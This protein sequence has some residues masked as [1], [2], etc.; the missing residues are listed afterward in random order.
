MHLYMQM[1]HV[2]YILLFHDLAAMGTVVGSIPPRYDPTESKYGN[3]RAIRI[4]DLPDVETILITPNEGKSYTWWPVAIMSVHDEYKKGRPWLQDWKFC[5]CI[6]QAMWEQPVA[7][8]IKVSK[9]VNF[10]SVG[11]PFFF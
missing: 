7:W 3:K 10:P 4:R 6:Y 8:G 5:T 11:V 2:F 9:M 1:F